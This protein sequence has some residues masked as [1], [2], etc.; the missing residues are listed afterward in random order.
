MEQALPHEGNAAG[1][2]PRYLC[3][4]RSLFSAA[5]VCLLTIL[6][7]FISYGYKHAP[8]AENDGREAL[9]FLQAVL[10]DELQ[11]NLTLAQNAAIRLAGLNPKAAAELVRQESLL[12]PSA[13]VALYDER[14][15]VVE[16]ETSPASPNSSEPMAAGVF[17]L[18]QK[19]LRGQAAVALVEEEG[20]VAVAAAAPVVG[21]SVEC[22]VVSRP[23]A[24]AVLLR[25]KERTGSDVAVLI[26]D[27]SSES[28]KIA[29]FGNAHYV[30][31]PQKLLQT[32][33][34]RTGPVQVQLSFADYDSVASACLAGGD[35][36]A[37]AAILVAMPSYTA[38]ESAWPVPAAEV[39][40]LAFAGALAVFVAFSYIHFLRECRYRASIAAELTQFATTGRLPVQSQLPSPLQGALGAIAGDLEKYKALAG[41]AVEERDESRR[42]L[43]KAES[44]PGVD[45]ADSGRK[46]FFAD[47]DVGF[48]V[49]GENGA[50]LQVN[51]YFAFMLGY[52][53]P[54]HLLSERSALSG[55][56]RSAEEGTAL[57]ALLRET[58]H[59]KFVATLRRRD[60]TLF[61]VT[62][63][64]LGVET[65]A[66]GAL[67]TI[68]G[69]ITDRNLEEQNSQL[70]W[71]NRTVKKRSETL[72][73]LLAATCRQ[74]Q[75]YI[76]P[77]LRGE[78]QLQ[79]QALHGETLEA[80]AAC[81]TVEP[82]ELPASV[83][84]DGRSFEFSL[85]SRICAEE[86]QQPLAQQSIFDDI[87][88]IALEEAQESRAL[89]APMNI[90]EVL[91]HACLQALPI[92]Q[93][94]GTALFRE[95]EKELAPQV[96]GPA[97]ILR[98]AL[99]RALLEV[100]GAMQG[101]HAFLSAVRD[102]NS[103]FEEGRIKLLFSAS[104]TSEL[105]QED[106]PRPQPESYGELP[107]PD[108]SHAANIAFNKADLG[109]SLEERRSIMLFLVQKMHGELRKSSFTETARSVQFTAQFETMMGG[110]GQIFPA[111]GEQ[112][113]VAEKK[114]GKGEAPSSVKAPELLRP[115]VSLHEAADIAPLPLASPAAA[116]E[117]G[118]VL[119]P[120]DE[121]GYT[122]GSEI[123]LAA[124]EDAVVH[125]LNMD[126]GMQDD[127]EDS[128]VDDSLDILLI[129]DSMNNR[130]LFSMFLRDTRH[131]ITEAHNGQEGV[132][133]FQNQRFDVIF[134]DM[135]MPL[136]NGYQAT[137]IIR[138]MEADA[139]M[140]PTPI[141]AQTAHV[142]PDFKYQCM[143]AGCTEFLGKPFSKNALLTMTK[144]FSRLKRE[145]MRAAVTD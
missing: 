72:A 14:G 113:A 6:L 21:S 48:F 136:M 65:D 64:S 79:P 74:V 29:T 27:M 135:E 69:M 112:A 3:S 16:R 37:D 101:G 96:S 18:V 98:H 57:L 4:A 54:T 36:G 40:L 95:V 129:D 134:M 10:E 83:N 15:A 117:S 42:R 140:E 82:R 32:L 66:E 50:F 131:R 103:P 105:A 91:E 141:V 88:T 45:V 114:T 139:G 138:A 70:L 43:E 9:P 1:S 2:F 33:A 116:D 144:A 75:A 77:N 59:R 145:R 76:L 130:L 115:S 94:G 35:Q 106:S 17:E 20:G 123:P 13:R 126:P 46:I 107:S 143:L 38:K 19:A 110:G 51:T 84:A 58:V 41:K 26:P 111:P 89:V 30:L 61:E 5:G 55:I 71:E 28:G 137:R 53:S 127:E 8:D 73:L 23:L 81:M 22:V 93:G 24:M 78:G 119:E 80:G 132:E 102:P 97:V 34:G 142:L 90:T 99:L 60:N 52:D 47:A 122:D 12:L 68:A 128:D 62:A 85:V 118:D 44:V 56:C 104:W 7:V 49:I 11:Q 31:S 86:G 100:A 109:F 124:E 67:A 39:L 121:G 133:A 120:F 25:V 125:L 108:K 87:Y 92:L 63:S